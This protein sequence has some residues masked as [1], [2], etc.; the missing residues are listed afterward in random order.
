MPVS[1]MR[2]VLPAWLVS[3]TAVGV[4]IEDEHLA[5]R[6]T[7]PVAAHTAVANPGAFG[8]CAVAVQAAE[9]DRGGRVAGYV[10]EKN[11]VTDVGLAVQSLVRTG[12]ERQDGQPIG[13]DVVVGGQSD[14]HPAGLR[15][16]VHTDHHP[17][18][19]RERLARQVGAGRF[20][21][22]RRAQHADEA[23]R[24]VDQVVDGGEQM[25]VRQHCRAGDPRRDDPDGDAGTEV[26]VADHH[27]TEDAAGGGRQADRVV[28][29]RIGGVG[30]RERP[31]GERAGAG[32][33]TAV[34]GVTVGGALN[35]GGGEEVPAAHLDGVG[36]GDR[37]SGDGGLQQVE[38]P[39]QLTDVSVGTRR[40]RQQFEP[41]VDDAATTCR[42]ADMWW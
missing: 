13:L 32:R 21:W 2:T 5:V 20:G 23:A 12:A 3:R 6:R 27:G 15:R 1:S 37:A 28:G 36:G 24:V 7:H 25:A 40:H 17:E 10:G 33:G 4:A 30:T 16:I 22:R 34:D 19:D 31:A 39:G 38:S 18:G 42:P 11:E 29:Q 35:P 9:D 26:G 14:P 8:R 41:V